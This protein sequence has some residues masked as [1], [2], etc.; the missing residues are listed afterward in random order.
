LG[1]RSHPA[2]ISFA[3]G[4]LARQR[5]RTAALFGGVTMTTT[6][7][8]AVLFTTSALK[9]EAERGRAT[10]PD[11]LVQRLVG[12]RPGLID[13]NL[14]A[15]VADMPG[16]Q[17]VVP[18]VWGY[19]FLPSL[20]ANVTVIARRDEAIDLGVVRGAL[21]SGRDARPGERGAAVIGKSLA[22]LLRVREGDVMS[23]PSADPDTPALTVVGVFGS[24]VALYTSDVLLVATEDARAILGVPAPHATDIA[25]DLVNPEEATVVT[26]AIL[27]KE[28]DLR[29][30]DKR[31][32]A[33][34][35]R[36]TYGRRAGIVLA[37]SL[38]AL[39][40]MLL[41]A[42]DKMAGTGPSERHEIAVEKAVGWSTADVLY[43]KLYE[44]ALV[45]ILGFGA[46]IVVAYGWVFLLEAPFLREVLSGW[47]VLYPR[48]ALTP[49]IDPADLAGLAAMVLAPFIAAAIVPAWRAAIVD[50]MQAMR[51]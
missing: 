34:T 28:P 42:W 44:S 2:L 47:S 13:P 14:V 50:P 32:L 19:V 37:A 30:L 49:S 5:G 25:I 11:V 35:Y 36:L 1:P 43:A 7:L 6:L 26:R 41:L 18:R 16:V 10:Q 40:V 4:A 21:M 51:S 31:V 9:A 45:G 27:E 29:V 33:R 8:A 22:D 46:G 24:P 15:F 17:R 38:P 23:L 12:G 20:R 48:V 3:W 39:L